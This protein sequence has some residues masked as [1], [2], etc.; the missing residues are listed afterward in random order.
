VKS[1]MNAMT[2]TGKRVQFHRVR[3]PGGCAHG[4]AAR[5]GLPGVVIETSY[6]GR[7]IAHR[8]ALRSIS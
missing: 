7:R 5:Q 1:R 3:M 8:M 6:D 4:P 2:M